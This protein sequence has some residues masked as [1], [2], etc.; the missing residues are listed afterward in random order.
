MPTLEVETPHG[1]A[2]AHVHA[3][4]E[5]RAALVLGHGAAGGR[6]GEGRRVVLGGDVPS[7]VDPPP[8]C[9]F[10]T[11]CWKA[12]QICREIEP[13]LE[14][15]APGDLSAYHLPLSRDEVEEIAAAGEQAA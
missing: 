2:R 13:P 7:P 5:P 9:R 11:R 1:L 6:E 15:K 8:A 4:E 3:A 14:P 10:D 12:Q